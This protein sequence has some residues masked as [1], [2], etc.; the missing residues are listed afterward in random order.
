M[1]CLICNDPNTVEA[2][3]VPRALYRDIA[4]KHQ[5]GYESSRFKHGVNYQAKGLYDP[6]ILCLEHEGML[7]DAD[8]YGIAFIRNFHTTGSAVV[9]NHAWQVANPRP[10]LLV[11]FVASL[12]WRRGVSMVQREQADLDLG[13]AEPRLRGL[14]FEGST[15]YNP[16]LIVNKRPITSQGTLLHELMFEPAKHFGW[17]YNS[18][19]FYVMGVE[20]VMKLNPYSSEPFPAFFVVNEQIKLLAANLKPVEIHT[21]EGAI[22]IAANMFTDAKTGMARELR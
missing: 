13:P 4:G 12:I 20:F 19:S 3:I 16:P 9:D 18:W 22:D 21:I 5:H 8:T 7:G 6:N 15:T 2:H 1:P 11:K 10:D 14:L 17:G